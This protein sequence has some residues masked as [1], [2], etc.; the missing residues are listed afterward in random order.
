MENKIL[1]HCRICFSKKLT[2]YFDLGKQ[3]FSN[4][5]LNYKNLKNEKSGNFF[6]RLMGERKERQ[7]QISNVEADDGSETRYGFF[8]PLDLWTSGPVGL[9]I[10]LPSD[11]FLKRGFFFLKRHETCC[12]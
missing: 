6:D 9:W 12:F 11:F 1:N 2:S 8:G 3:P 10:C 7:E 5:F 4:S